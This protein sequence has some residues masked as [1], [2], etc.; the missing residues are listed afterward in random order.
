[1]KITSLEVR[2]FRGLSHLRASLDQRVFV[3]GA[4]GSGKTSL[5]QAIAIPLMRATRKLRHDEELVSTGLRLPAATKDATISLKVSFE[6]NE[7]AATRDLLQRY[8]AQ[9]R[10]PDPDWQRAGATPDVTLTTRGRTTRT[11]EGL[12]AH[13]Q[14]AG[15]FAIK[16]LIKHDPGLRDAFKDVGDVFLFEYGSGFGHEICEARKIIG[17]WYRRSPE[18][19]AA[20]MDQMEQVFNGISFENLVWDNENDSAQVLFKRNN[21]VYELEEMSLGEKYV[22]LTLVAI[23]KLQISRSV[24]LIDDLDAH[25]D[26]DAVCAFWHVLED[27][28][29]DS[30]IIATTKYVPDDV[31]GTLIELQ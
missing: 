3:T 15:R 24:V 27:A 22:L 23:Q 7:L 31:P 20:V 30:Q 12:G 18:E 11:D 14:F 6:T 2:S 13:L 26:D 29:P 16:V 10:E 1:M 19:F 9:R 21:R 8:N 25:L 28:L 17:S 4:P 5:L